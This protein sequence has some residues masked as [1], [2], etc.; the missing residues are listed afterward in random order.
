[1][2]F[3]ERSFFISIARIFI[4][5]SKMVIKFDSFGLIDLLFKFFSALLLFARTRHQH[6]TCCAFMMN[7]SPCSLICQIITRIQTG[8][9]Y[10]IINHNV[11]YPT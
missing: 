11:E 4:V 3:C 6:M 10:K 5:R 9:S 2:T 7:C 1:M 8:V